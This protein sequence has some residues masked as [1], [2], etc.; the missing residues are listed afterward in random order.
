MKPER[1]AFA[2]LQQIHVEETRG[3]LQFAG[4]AKRIENCAQVN[5]VGATEC[6][7]PPQAARQ[8]GCLCRSQTRSPKRCT[9]Y[10]DTCLVLHHPA[11]L[12]L[13]YFWA[14]TF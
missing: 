2:F 10:S 6:L 1:I 14:S 13:V 9:A 5:E 8:E 3:T 11:N 4:R 7:T 12:V